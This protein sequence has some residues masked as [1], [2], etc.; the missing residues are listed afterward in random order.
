MD[1]LDKCGLDSL[2]KDMKDL[3]V[4]V[5]SRERTGVREEK[6]IFI[7]TSHLIVLFAFFFFFTMNVQLKLF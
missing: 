4:R 1:T 6:L 2:F 5:A 3:A 7:F